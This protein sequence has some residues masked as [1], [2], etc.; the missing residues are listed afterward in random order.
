MRL[1]RRIVTAAVSV[2]CFAALA[3]CGQRV[4]AHVSAG[5]TVNAALSGL[6]NSNTTRFDMTAQGLPGTAAL[7]DGS[8]SIVATTSKA[9][10]GSQSTDDGS[11]ALSVY[12]ES[13]DLADLTTVGGSLYVRL[14]LKNITSFAS[15]GEFTAISNEI[16]TQA[17]RPGYGFLRDVLAGKWVGVSMSTYMSVYRQYLSELSSLLPSSSSQ[18][19]SLSKLEK[20]AQNTKQLMR[21]RA[22]IMSALAQSVKSWLS[23]HQKAAGEY[24][25]SLP[26]RSFVTTLVDKLIG[27][28]EAFVNDPAL[29]KEISSSALSSE[30]ARIPSSLSLNANLWITSGSVTKIQAFIPDTTAY[31]M[32]G[33]SYPSTPVAA[34]SGA[35]MLTKSDLEA[36]MSS[37]MSTIKSGSSAISGISSIPMIPASSGV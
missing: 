35:T 5:D 7:I 9:A 12:H 19:P 25:L 15:P 36:I 32:I 11:L 6:L 33:V 27:P 18:S 17:N 10:G 16:D 20:L 4:V 22:E 13:T 8:F 28:I 2:T 26:I 3:A 30:L 37:M 29:T 31:L 21:L 24:A 23:I 14:D 34:P 1:R